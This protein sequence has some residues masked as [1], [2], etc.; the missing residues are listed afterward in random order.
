[1]FTYIQWLNI[2]YTNMTVCKW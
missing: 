1:M 2:V